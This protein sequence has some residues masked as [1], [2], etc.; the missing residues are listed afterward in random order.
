MQGVRMASSGRQV[1]R[2]HAILQHQ[3]GV[4]PEV[5][6]LLHSPAGDGDSGHQPFGRPRSRRQGRTSVPRSPRIFLAQCDQQLPGSVGHVPVVS[7]PSDSNSRA[8]TSAHAQPRPSPPALP[9]GTPWLAWSRWRRQGVSWTV[10]PQGLER[11]AVRSAGAPFRDL[12]S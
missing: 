3:A 11:G 12:E 7:R 9:L 1:H 10:K 4:R 5:Q 6:Q 2:R 8:A